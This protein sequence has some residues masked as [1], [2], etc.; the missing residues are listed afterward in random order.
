MRTLRTMCQ[1]ATVMLYY[2][3]RRFVHVLSAF[4][5]WTEIVNIEPLFQTYQ[6]TTSFDLIILIDIE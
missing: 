3:K 5:P 2:N 4:A 1:A 6:A